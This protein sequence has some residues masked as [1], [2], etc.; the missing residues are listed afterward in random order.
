MNLYY[1]SVFFSFVI[2]FG[3]LGLIT[4]TAL[5]KPTDGYYISSIMLFSFFV[6]LPLLFVS[7][8][9]RAKSKMKPALVWD[10]LSI[11]VVLMVF[12]IFISFFELQVPHAVNYNTIILFI[13]PILVG[14]FQYGY[15]EKKYIKLNF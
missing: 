7:G 10:Y 15:F 6:G 4:T 9:C 1:W 14:I 8:V 12:S 3:L 11:I 2:S 13:I 5:S